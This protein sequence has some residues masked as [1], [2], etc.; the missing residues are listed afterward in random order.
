MNLIDAIVGKTTEYENK[1]IRAAAHAD[2]D[3]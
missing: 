3:G 2:G 1:Y